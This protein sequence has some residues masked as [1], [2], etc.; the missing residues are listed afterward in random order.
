MGF[1]SNLWRDALRNYHSMQEARVSSAVTFTNGVYKVKTKAGKEVNAKGVRVSKDSLGGNIK[2]H[3][4]EDP[5]GEYEVYDF[6]AKDK[7]GLI[8]DEII[9][10]GTTIDF[11]H[12]KILC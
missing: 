3:L 4:V 9:E 10:D 7:E 6:E 11:S 2:V 12:V 1:L 5:V 8:F